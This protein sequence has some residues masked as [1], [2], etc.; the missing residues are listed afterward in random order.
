MAWS[1]SEGDIGRVWEII[2]VGLRTNFL[3]EYSMLA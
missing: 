2:K 1:V 3:N